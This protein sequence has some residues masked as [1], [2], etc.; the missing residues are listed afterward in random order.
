MGPCVSC[1]IQ[2]PQ[3]FTT[4][5]G[6][7]RSFQKTLLSGKFYGFMIK[8]LE[9]EQRNRFRG[10][11]RSS[12]PLREA[13]TDSAGCLPNVHPPL[14]PYQ[15]NSRLWFFWG[16]GGGGEWARLKRNFLASLGSWVS[17]LT[18]SQPI[19]CK[20]KSTDGQ[21]T[22]SHLFFGLL[23]FL[24]GIH[25]YDGDRLEIRMIAEGQNRA[26]QR[27]LGFQCIKGSLN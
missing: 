4:A 1:M 2:R 5:K 18:Q 6:W 25:S 7:I 23:H 15:Q 17:H 11:F 24:P 12:P 16:G 3:D 26:G 21:L 20:F 9:L 27:G 8:S 10:P 14:L 19:S 22:D 13:A